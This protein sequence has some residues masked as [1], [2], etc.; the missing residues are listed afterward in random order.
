M[1]NL[2]NTNLLPLMAALFLAVA[3]ISGAWFFELV[4]RLAPCPLCLTQRW[5]YYIGIP[6]LLVAMIMIKNGSRNAAMITVL[7]AGIL[8]AGGAVLAVYHSGIEWRFWEGPAGCSG[9]QDLSAS[10]GNLLQDLKTAQV[11]SCV[12]AAWRFLGISLAGY[13]VIISAIISALCFITLIQLRK[14]QGSSS[15]S[16]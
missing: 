14:S 5:P 16:Q 6:L 7:A 11:V 10:V 3:T 15:I 13:N 9:G 12:D 2:Q 8:F 1:K 4:L